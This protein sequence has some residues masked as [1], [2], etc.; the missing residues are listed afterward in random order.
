MKCYIYQ[1]IN[2]VTQEKYVGQTTN[3][4]RRK[5]NHL[6]ALKN[7]HHPN[8]KL[9][10]AWNKYGEDNFRWVVNSYDISKAELDNL[11]KEIIAREKS[12]SNGYNLTEGGTG[13]NTH[14][15]RIINFEQ[16][17]FIYAGNTHFEGMTGKTARLIGCDSS[18]ISAIKRN[19]SYDDYREAY[20]LLSEEKKQEYLDQFVQCFGL[21][22]NKPPKQAGRLEDE[23]VVDFLCLT[24]LYGKGAEIAF[25][26]ATNHAKGLGHQIKTNKNY[27][28]KSKQIYN[29]LTDEEIKTRAEQVYERYAIQSY[30]TYKLAKKKQVTRVD[31]A[32]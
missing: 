5:E 21:D 18:T 27:F 15:N 13:G 23:Q 29:A 16:F 19:V 30:L 10:N 28:V 4:S 22:F 12:F 32:L 9:Q 14:F 17:C 20:E 1:I 6:S 2:Q 3:F 26:R 8:Q 11:E 31:C 24:S 25:L 7:N